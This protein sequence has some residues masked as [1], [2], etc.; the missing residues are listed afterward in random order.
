MFIATYFLLPYILE[1]SKFKSYNIFDL[2]RGFQQDDRFG[3]DAR[4][5]WRDLYSVLV[6]LH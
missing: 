4:N 5:D 2:V 1:N 3:F 6:Q